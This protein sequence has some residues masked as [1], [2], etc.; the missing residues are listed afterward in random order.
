MQH[1][2]STMESRDNEVVEALIVGRSGVYFVQE[3]HLEQPAAKTYESDFFWC[4][5]DK[6][7]NNAGLL[8]AEKWIKYVAEARKISE[9]FFF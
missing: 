5:N 3:A 4:D 7:T 1:E 9:R 8:I 6:G 2:I